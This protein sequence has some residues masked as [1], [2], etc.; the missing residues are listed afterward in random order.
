ML[1]SMTQSNEIFHGVQ[2]R[3]VNISQQSPHLLVS[4]VGRRSHTRISYDSLRIACDRL[5]QSIFSLTRLEECATRRLLLIIL[6]WISVQ[7]NSSGW[8]TEGSEGRW[9]RQAYIGRSV[10]LNYQVC[11]DKTSGGFYIPTHCPRLPA[12]VTATLSAE[13]R[14]DGRPMCG[15]R[16]G[17]WGVCVGVEGQAD[18]R[19]GASPS[20]PRS[21]LSHH[22]PP[23]THTHGGDSWGLSGARARTD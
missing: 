3:R 18:A 4:G 22:A 17:R 16:G 1:H 7:D 5:S 9:V 19:A 2:T 21:S 12:N 8:R 11:R 20:S 14:T 23:H 15:G 10:I 13:D 6:K